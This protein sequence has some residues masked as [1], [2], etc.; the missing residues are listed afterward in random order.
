MDPALWEMIQGDADQEVEAIIRLKAHAEAPPGVRI[1]SRFGDIA[2]CRLQRGL[3][4]QV[5]D[6]EEVSSLKAPRLLVPDPVEDEGVP[7]EDIE[8]APRRPDVS[9]AGRGVVLGVIDWGCDFAHP[10]FLTQ[11]GK[12]RLLALWDQRGRS[13]VTEANP[14]GRGHIHVQ[15]EIDRALTSQD[16]YTAL[17]YHPQDADTGGGTHGTHVMDIAAGGGAAGGPGG[18]APRAMLV[19]VHLSSSGTGGLANFGDNVAL[20]EAID[21]VIRTAAGRPCV[22]NLSMGR[23][24]G[25]H[26][27]STLVEQGMDAALAST[28][29][30]AIVTSTG[31]YYDSRVHAAGRLRPGATERLFWKVDPADH[32]PN[33]LEIWYS[34]H[35]RLAVELRAPQGES[36]GPVT[37][38]EHRTVRVGEQAVGR[39][40]HRSRDPNNL[41]NHIDIFL[42]PGGPS[43]RWEVVLSGGEVV[44]G[45]FDGWIERD[46]GRSQNQSR[47]DA[48]EAS[49]FGTTGTIANGFHPIAVG[50]YDPHSAGRPL[51]H[52]SSSGPTRDGRQKPELVAPGVRIVAAASAPGEGEERG[53]LTSKSG[54]SMAAPHVAGT[55]ALMMEAAGRPLTIA[56]T[57]GLLIGHTDDVSVPEEV[58]VRMG[59]GYLNTAR[60]VDAART[61]MDES[62]VDS[63]ASGH[64]EDGVSEAG[65]EAAAS[66]EEGPGST[67]LD[68]E[69]VAAL[70]PAEASA[71]YDA[72]AVGPEG[73][74]EVAEEALAEGGAA[75]S[76]QGL[77]DG[78]LEAAGVDHRIRA[79]ISPR[80]VFEAFSTT[81]ATG[82]VLESIFERVAPPGGTLD[83]GLQRGD[84]LIRVPLGE[85]GS[86]HVAV[87][88]N[89]RLLPRE[90][91]EDCDLL[92]E[93]LEPG[94]YAQVVEG[95][96]RPHGVESAFAR[97]VLD[98]AGRLPAGQMV[99][100]LRQWRTDD[101]I[102]FGEAIGDGSPFVRLAVS[103]CWDRC[104]R[105]RRRASM[106]ANPN[107]VSAAGI[108]RETG[109]SVDRNPYFGVTRLE[110]E[111]VIR[112]GYTSSQ[113]PELLLALWSKEGSTRSVTG[114]RPVPQASDAANARTL[115]R[116]RV[117]YEDLGADHFL[118]TRYDPARH[119]SVWDAS[120]AAAAGHERHFIQRVRT[121]YRAGLLPEDI[122]ATI[123]GELRAR[124]SA[125]V[126]EV[127]PTVKFYALSLLLV[128]AL[129]T[130]MQR[131]SFPQ[132]S[133]ISPHLNYLQ[134]NMGSRRF[135]R[136]LSS[137][138]RHRREPRYRS[139][140]GQAISI[141]DWAL[142]RRP[143]PRE[144]RQPR[145]NAIRFMHL[146]QSYRPIFLPAITL[147]KPGIEDLQTPP[148]GV[149][150]A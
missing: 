86:A 147:I 41:S 55:I 127:R 67:M 137:A 37:L 66:E 150:Y 113:M 114:F 65:I 82:R 64:D 100:R 131:N 132:L 145:I 77:L 138:D 63:Q 42:Y 96:A 62:I 80:S 19:F 58:R 48:A 34:G 72:G 126:W 143:R 84:L 141:E 20:L 24:G 54:T 81:G 43:G 78:L 31:N 57:R 29:G 112:A 98:Q 101:A 39:I 108:L 10:N 15:A 73:C 119:D 27:G 51:A 144:W 50:A 109:V 136:F 70:P 121:L 38:G 99:L 21:Y 88:A 53:L 95:D 111:A 26:D 17:G 69:P 146:A 97:R 87:V 125:G 85:P 139:A 93:A 149:A 28:P 91:F 30:L 123:N 105:F 5:H 3:I 74:V 110:I 129:Y 130:Q 8:A 90:A 140:S 1:V 45:R 12:T 124:R 7:G 11:E 103:Q 89:E 13:P 118:V 22:I 44:D 36:S 40:Y 9:E 60:A 23:H 32:T 92:A 115:F 46:V 120:D 68:D 76:S 2:T 6:S 35:D 25:P 71:I 107:R 79:G 135:G 117:Y 47:F 148:T 102:S 142:H 116:C 134:W 106:A 122:S 104:K 14:Y 52:F 18:V 16:P 59:Y 94:W 49:P 4:R 75:L 133:W 83:L 61:G 128:D 56:E 33:E